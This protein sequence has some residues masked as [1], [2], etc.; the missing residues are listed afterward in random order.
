MAL[1]QDGL[2]LLERARLSWRDQ[3]N[4]YNSAI[5]KGLDVFKLVRVVPDDFGAADDCFIGRRFFAIGIMK[6]YCHIEDDYVEDEDSG[7]YV[8][9]TRA[10]CYRCDHETTA[11]GTTEGSR[12]RCLYLMGQECP[13]GE[14]NFYEEDRG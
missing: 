10:T 9:G 2:G 11:F 13:K 6:V 8:S 12:K 14:S 7:R 4:S 5:A 1:L 3:V